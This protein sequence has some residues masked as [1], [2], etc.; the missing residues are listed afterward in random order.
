VRDLRRAL[1]FP[2][3]PTPSEAGGSLLLDHQV[4]LAFFVMTTL[5]APGVNALV[6]VLYTIPFPN[7]YIGPDGY[8][9]DGFLWGPSHAAV[10]SLFLATGCGVLLRREPMALLTRWAVVSFLVNAVIWAIFDIVWV[11][12]WLADL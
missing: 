6:I 2:L 8:T 9:G 3:L 10:A 11:I 7:T 12:A 5:F 4:G 1:G